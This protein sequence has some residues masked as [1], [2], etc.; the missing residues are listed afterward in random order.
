M[1][2]TNVQASEHYDFGTDA[3]GNMAI[4][5]ALSSMTPGSSDASGN[6]MIGQNAGAALTTGANNIALGALALEANTTG[7]SNNA[8]SEAALTDN[9]TGTDNTAIGTGA[10]TANTTASNNVAI[11]S[12]A[13]E[14]NTTGGS[15]TAVGVQALQQANN[16]GCVAIGYLALNNCTS[17]YNTA[18]GTNALQG[19]TGGDRNTAVGAGAGYSPNGNTA[20]ATIDGEYNT[21]IGYNCG[22]S[23]STDVYATV[24]IGYLTLVGSSNAVAVGSPPTR[25]AP[26]PWRSARRRAPAASMPSPSD[27]ARA[28]RLSAP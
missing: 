26:M 4:G 24:A 3:F 27:R 20:N 25:G 1:P 13:L 12:D 21:F 2:L 6:A 10:L 23:S 7:D 11:G 17:D 8:L 28:R 5:A 9:T 14:T 22:A 19:I 16:G 15:N 18:V